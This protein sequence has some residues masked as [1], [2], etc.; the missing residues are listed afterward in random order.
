MTL[1]R[2]LSTWRETIVRVALK[3][4]N[5]TK[6]IPE[7]ASIWRRH[8]RQCLPRTTAARRPTRAATVHSTVTTAASAADQKPSRSNGTDRRVFSAELRPS[9]GCVLMAD[10]AAVITGLRYAAVSSGLLDQSPRFSRAVEE[11]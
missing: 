11:H 7:C 6:P 3:I 1:R 2:W 9:P 8:R 10:E 4:D 5:F